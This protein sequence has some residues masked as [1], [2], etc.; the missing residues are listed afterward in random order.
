MSIM[1]RTYFSYY[2]S[3]IGLIEI[4]GTPTAITELNFVEERRQDA[5]S[6][7]YVR[8]IKQQVAE[9]FEGKRRTFD[10]RLALIGTDFQQHVWQRLQTVPYGRTASYQDI[11]RGIG[12]PAAV[13][14]VGAANGRNPVAII[15]PCHRIIGKNGRL[16]GYGSGLWRKEWLLRHEGALSI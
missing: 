4:V 13:R 10:I 7:T 1:N 11:A 6:H 8:K 14:A 3:P 2:K 15:V 16:V 5:A 12:R 9:Y